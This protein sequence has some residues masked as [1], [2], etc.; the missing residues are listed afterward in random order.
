LE[1]FWFGGH[2]AGVIEPPIGNTL[3]SGH[4]SRLISFAI[5]AVVGFAILFEWFF[6]WSSSDATVKLPFLKKGDLMLHVRLWVFWVGLFLAL[7]R[8]SF[9]ADR[10]AIPGKPEQASALKQVRELFAAEYA[11]TSPHGRQVL[12]DKLSKAARETDDSTVGYVLLCEV[13]DISAGMG[14][15]RAALGAAQRLDSLYA[16]HPWEALLAALLELRKASLSAVSASDAVMAGMAA[17]DDSLSSGDVEVAIKLAA[18]LD[19]ITARVSDRELAAAARQHAT[20][21]RAAMAERGRITPDLKVL[22]EHPGD[23]RASLMVGR[24]LCFTLG[25]WDEGLKVLMNVAEPGLRDLA[26]LDRSNPL[27]ARTEVKIGDGWAALAESAR[28]A[29]RVHLNERAAMWYRRALA[30]LTGLEKLRVD[31]RLSTAGTVIKPWDSTAYV[32]TSDGKGIEIGM[33]DRNVSRSFLIQFDVKTTSKHS[34]VLLT[35][36]KREGD[37][38]ITISLSSHGMI[39]VADDGSFYKQSAKGKAV[40]NDGNWHTIRVEKQ[41]TITKFFVDNV[42]E[43]MVEVRAELE[44]ASPWTLGYHETWHSEPL[45]AEFRHVRIEGE[46]RAIR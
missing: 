18:A 44:S 27:D 38:S 1:F 40:V 15:A 4:R 43:G 25:Q 39:E 2:G 33:A 9:A 32:T 13:R 3:V 45:D 23:P 20:D 35:K 26:V 36:R 30:S 7:G 28:G 19:P 14:N 46:G 17:M 22:Q 16:E 8:G 5:F 34:A 10:L 41:G 12:T 37:S 11:D 21:G 29:A 6:L 24:F 31:K 42:P